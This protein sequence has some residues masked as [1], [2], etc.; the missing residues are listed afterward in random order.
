MRYRSE[1]LALAALSVFVVG[2]GEGMLSNEGDEGPQFDA[3][4]WNHGF[5]FQTL[6]R[7][8]PMDY[9]HVKSSSPVDGVPADGAWRFDLSG[10][11][12]VRDRTFNN[13][14][15][16][17][18]LTCGGVHLVALYN[19]AAARWDTLSH[20]RRDDA[21]AP[22]THEIF[23]RDLGVAEYGR[24]AD[25]YVDV[26]GVILTRGLSPLIAL[27]V[28]PYYGF[29]I[30][31]HGVGLVR[32][33]NGIWTIGYVGS[34]WGIRQYSERGDSLD[35]I[36]VRRMS[37]TRYPVALAADESAFWIAEDS[38]LLWRITR[39][40]AKLDSVA[41]PRY[42]RVHAMAVAGDRLVIAVN[43]RYPAGLLYVLD[44][45]ASLERGEW[46]SDPAITVP[47]VQARALSWHGGVLVAATDS[48]Y[49]I[50]SEAGDVHARRPHPVR[51]VSGIAVDGSSVWFVDSGLRD[52]PPSY[53][54]EVSRFEI[55]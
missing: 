11:S 2:C 24:V 42:L 35:W 48:E 52:S 21:T 23:F 22:C 5:P 27:R 3:A 31:S 39:D 44:A 10:V 46:V 50:L 28:D 49:V 9:E 33:L 14:R 20:Y 4:Y 6:D 15:G 53:G 54:T 36:A 12:M 41:A 30:P 8:T 55:P 40:G 25:D 19:V 13:L 32:D 17:Y 16:R 43:G 18:S 45:P 37:S 1:L 29:P 51:S 47:S 38:G 34:K 26:D 7:V